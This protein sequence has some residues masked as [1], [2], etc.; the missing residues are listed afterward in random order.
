MEEF[1]V[2]LVGDRAREP[3]LA[4][5]GRA[6]EQHALGR[7]DAEPLEQFGIAQRQLDHLADLVDRVAQS[8]EIVIGDV[9]A[10]R[11]LGLL[12]F[13][14]QLDLGGLVDMDDALGRRRDDDETHL[15]QRIS[16]AVEHLAQLRRQI[17]LRHA[18]LARRR[19]DIARGHRL[20][21][22][23]ALERAARSLEPQILLR[24]RE[25]DALRR[26]ALDLAHLD[27]VARADAR[28]GA[29]EPVEAQDIEPLVLGIGQHRARRR[30]ALADD[31]DDVALE[32]AERLHRAAGQAREAV[33]A[34]VGSRI[35]DLQLG[36][37]C[38][39]GQVEIG[40]H[41]L[42]CGCER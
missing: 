36:R 13:G 12:I 7:L 33:A 26:L 24:G 40:H 17:L 3:R 18:L 23:A 10:A 15:L 21:L 9:G 42:R 2:A 8:A 32:H 25:H 41:P 31:L 5:A 29:L 19:D 6:V 30:R 38:I 39:G 35:G 14:A 4:G 11:L 37:A 28:I 1:G 22:E 20:H 34:V 27:I 16:G